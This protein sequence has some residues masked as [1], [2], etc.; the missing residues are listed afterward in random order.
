M[1]TSA[2]ETFSLNFLFLKKAAII[3]VTRGGSSFVPGN[4]RNV[5]N[6]KSNVKFGGSQILNDI[7]SV[8]YVVQLH[9]Y[10][11]KSFSM[12]LLLTI[13]INYI[14]LVLFLHQT[15]HLS[16]GTCLNKALINT[17]F[18]CIFWICILI[19]LLSF[20]DVLKIG[21]SIFLMWAINIWHVFILYS[22]CLNVMYCYVFTL[23]YLL[24]MTIDINNLSLKFHL[25][26][27]FY[28]FI[29]RIFLYSFSSFS[30]AYV[31]FLY[32]WWYMISSINYQHWII[33][34]TP[35]QIKLGTTN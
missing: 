3:S 23:E 30:H 16:I 4:W 10:I 29:S 1:D 8:C 32:I 15:K 24:L 25:N 18:F 12:I 21:L 22:L 9:I 11:V 33:T 27:F 19:K 34:L 28:F 13:T 2:S 14:F 20:C 5:L 6:L 35:G 31:L 17:V 26:G 7:V